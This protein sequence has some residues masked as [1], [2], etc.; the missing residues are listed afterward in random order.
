M[1][2]RIVICATQVPFAY[3]GAE[4]LV[5]SLRDELRSRDFEVDVAALPFHWPNRTELLKGSLAWR[6][7]NLTEAEG[8]R[9]DLVI[10]TRF[11]SYLVKHPNKV[12]WL[13]HQLRQ[14]YDLLGTRYS[15]FSDREP[16]DAKALAMI[17]AMDRRTLSEA[18]AV[19]T[20]SG[21]VAERLRRFNEIEAEV[22]YPPP[23]LDPLLRP[24]SFGDAIFTLGRLDP[25]KRFDL[26]V[27]A[28]KHTETPV[29]CLIGGSG[30]ERES[31]AA[32]IDRLGLQ[33]KV[34]LLGRI[35]DRDVV[36]Q[37]ANCLGVFYAPY[38]EDYGYVTV[39]AFKA[40]KPVITTADAGG[41][42]EFVEDGVNGFVCPS[43]S[44][45]EIGAQIDVLFRDR[46]RART[47]GLAGQTKVRQI[48]WDRVIER[49]TGYTGS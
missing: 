1:K 36:E 21:N 18:R 6:L 49:L 40:A 30:P 13:I 46:E 10:A 37:Y 14:A 45:S 3:G 43:D 11:P 48:T 2:P 28:M 23:K 16:R 41:V 8:R 20:I 4:M 27:R 35:E 39:E 31:L 12:V 9:I 5:D 22:L 34:E 32:L 26:L 24:G 19:Y 38:D 44:P 7:I 17:R 29:R 47:M 25:L 33:G 42:L 15:D